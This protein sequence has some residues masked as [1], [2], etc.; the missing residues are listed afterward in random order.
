[1]RNIEAGQAE[2]EERVTRNLRED[3]SRNIESTRQDFETQLATF[4]ARTKR[5][6]G[7]SAGTNADKV[8]PPKFD[9]ST[10]WVLFHRQFDAT[11]THKDWKPRK[12]V[13]H[14]LSILQGRAADVLHSV[15][16]EAS[17]E[18][19]VG[20]LQD[21]FG[22]HQLTAAYRSQL[23]AWVQT[24]NE[25]LQEFAAAVEQFAHWALVG[26]LADHIQTEAAHAFIDGIR[27]REVKQHLLLGGA[28]TLNEAISQAL[29][30][31][32]AKAAAWLT[33]R[34]R[35]VTRVPTERPPTPPERHRSERPVCWW[36]GQHGH[37]Q[38]YCRQRPP[39]EIGQDPKTRRRVSESSIT[40][41]RFTVKVLAEWAKGRLTADGWMQEKP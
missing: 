5:A 32:A 2:L 27:D 34:M 17:Y 38:K 13:A 15:T 36:C 29:K 11:A 25:T 18:D 22:D 28:Y 31:E 4:E 19:I 39:E 7:G 16:S 1:M 14:L 35:E 20:A 6:G 30:L 37:L 24:G 40:P 33:A 23:K 8:K 26:L 10:S 3:I 21:R 9:G 41:P 12:K